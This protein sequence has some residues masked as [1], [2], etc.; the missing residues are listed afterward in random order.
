VSVLRCGV[1]ARMKKTHFRPSVKEATID[2][3]WL[4]NCV[5][6]V[7]KYVVGN[8]QARIIM[9]LN[10]H[11]LSQV[12]TLETINQAPCTMNTGFVHSL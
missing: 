4:S 5:N 2:K 11:I 8:F 6:K 9:A 3:I 10:F 12:I 1:N 7:V